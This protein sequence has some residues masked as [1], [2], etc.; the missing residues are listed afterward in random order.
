MPLFGSRCNKDH[1]ILV[2][3][4]MEPPVRFQYFAPNLLDMI[5][6]LRLFPRSDWLARRL[7]RCHLGCD[8][9]T[10]QADMSRQIIRVLLTSLPILTGLCDVFLNHSKG[11]RSLSI[12]L[13]IYLSLFLSQ[14]HTLSLPTY[15]HEFEG[16][17]PCQIMQIPAS[18]PLSIAALSLP[19]QIIL[20]SRLSEPGDF[21]E[22]SA[23]QTETCLHEQTTRET[24]TSSCIFL[25]DKHTNSSN[26]I[27]TSAT[28]QTDLGD[29]Y[30]HM[31]NLFSRAS[32][33]T[34]SLFPLANK[35]LVDGAAAARSFRT[36]FNVDQ[37]E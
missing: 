3:I 14:T 33:P 4:L 27:K 15:S 30:N 1:N 36:N 34:A 31:Y 6:L 28:L 12:Y 19:K 35:K 17:D 24:K 37:V 2:S 20:R 7:V 10:F 13:S 25:H 26:L 29:G 9:S 5:F 16:R 8:F 22:H 21:V 18:F 11:G 32:P 23:L